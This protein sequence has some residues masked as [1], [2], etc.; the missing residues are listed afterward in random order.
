MLTMQ[1]A[2]CSKNAIFRDP[3][4]DVLKAAVSCFQS[5]TNQ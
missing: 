1:G 5:I 2:L 3:V 4:A